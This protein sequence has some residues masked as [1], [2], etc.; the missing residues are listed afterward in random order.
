[1]PARRNTQSRFPYFNRELSW[2]AFNRRVLEQAESEDYPI[3][4]RMKFLAFVSSNLDEFF[5]IRVAGLMQQVKSGVIELGPDGLGP[6]EQLRRIQSIT[7]RLVADQ[8]ECWEKQIVPGLEQSNVL[9]RDYD[10]LT[11]N[12]KKWVTQYFE[13]QIFPVLTPMAIDPA[14]PFP[15]LTNKA[16]YILASIDDPETRIIE[17]MMAIIPVPRILPRV[18]K[19]GVPRRGKPEVYIFLS[20]I[21]QKYIKWLFPG[22]KVRS[23]VPFRITRNSDL[24]IDEEEVENLLNKIEEELMNMNKGAAVRVEIGKGADPVLVDELL[25]AIHLQPEHV[26]TIGGPMNPLRLMSAYDLIDRPELKFAPVVPYTSQ[27]FDSSEHIFDRILESDIMLHQPYD[28][29]QPFID[30]INQAAKDPQVF[31]IKQTLY[32]TAG[33]SP[34]VAALIEASRRGKQVTV[35]VEIKARFD[36]ANNIAW[37]RRLEDVG[38]HVVYGLVGLKTHCKT[39]LVVRREGEKM[40]RYCHMGTGNYNHKTARLYTDIS[41]FTAKEDITEEVAG[42]FNTLT[43]FALTPG[44]KKL[45]VAP[46][47]L[48][49][50]IQ[51]YIKAETRNAKAGKPARIIAQTNSLVD[52]ATI[53]NLYR[54]SQAGVKID[55]IVRGICNLVP[56]IKGLS[57]NITVRS[58]LGRYLEHSRI[59]YFENTGNP[60]VFAGSADWMPRNF[61]RRIEAVFPVEE[62]ALRDRLIDILET[63]LKDTKN[64]RILRSNGAYHRISRARKGTKLVSAQ[65]V[66]AETAATRRKLQ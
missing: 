63:Y 46:F 22:Y 7:K 25:E 2:L 60:M 59:F 12:E 16:L 18:V 21:I 29:F 8:Y 56:N 50:K 49:S 14:H 65:D 61:Y 19:I 52:Q 47:T 66:F 28:T 4:E 42:L 23:A 30:F 44:F 9:F 24:Y 13:E 33:D 31:A 11:R 51:S 15:Q 41:F 40:R 55:L 10:E 54:A 62:P 3:L 32:R 64:A 37:A 39:C 38:V 26:Y 43:G 57:E 58:I 35:L 53:D 6:K 5:E 1:M 17:R 45:L 48:H 34:I 36:E 27:Q 20:D